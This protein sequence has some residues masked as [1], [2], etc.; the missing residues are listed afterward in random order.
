MAELEEVTTRGR[1]WRRKR[2]LLPTGFLLLVLLLLAIV[3]TQRVRI[4]T[5]YI[6]RELERRDVRASYT[7]TRIGFRTQRLEDVVIGDPARPDLTADRVE[8][9]IAWGLPGPTVSFIKARGVRLFGRI[10]DRKVS[11]GEVDKLL[12]EPTGKPFEFPD[13]NVDLADTA[14]VLDTQAGRLVGAI[15][16][17]GNLADGF[18]GEMTVLSSELLLG[19]CAFEEPRAYVDVAI[20]ERRPNIDGPISAERMLCPGADVDLANPVLNV[21][22]NVSETL[23]SWRGS[24]RLSV[25]RAQLGTNSAAGVTGRITFDGRKRL[26]RGRMDLTAV[27]AQIGDFSAARTTMQGRYAISLGTG[28]L[29][30]IADAAARGMRAQGP[31]VDSI[32]TALDGLGGTPVGPLGDAL[33]AAVRRAANG[34]D[35]VA[36]LRLVN[37]KGYGGVRFD[38]LSVSSRS[39]AVFGLNGGQ[40]LTYYWP[41]G[42]ARIDGEFGLT[43]GGFPATR[44]SLSQPRAGA[45]M[46]GEARVAPFAAGNARIALAPI[47]FRAE[48]DGTTRIETGMVLSGPFNDGYVRDLAL[49][50]VGRV[51]NGGFTLG[52]ECTPASFRSL[53][54]AELVLG[55]T[56]LALCPTG[57]ALVW[58]QGDGPLRGGAR[59]ERPLLVGRLGRNPIRISADSLRFDIDDPGFASSGVKVR[60]GAGEGAHWL[61]IGAISG[62]FDA[63]GVG[64]TFANASGKLSAVPILLSDAEG[65]WRVVDG[66]LTIEGATTVSDAQDPPRFWPLR[67]DDFRLTLVD[68]RID[69][70]A[71]LLDPETGT[72]VTDVTIEHSLETGIGNAVLDVPGIT[73]EVGGY[74]PDELTR[75]TTGVVALVDGTLTGKGRINWSPEGTTSTGTFSTADMDL[76]APFGPVEGL[77]TTV[78]FTD[79]LALESAPGQVAEVDLIQTG[80]DVVD[81]TIRYQL[82]RDLKVRVESGHW[83]FA[84]GD[85]FLEE[86][87]L[88][89]SKPTTKILTFRVVGLDAAT[90]VEQ[91]DFTVIEATGTFDG[92]IPMEFDQS[93]GRIIGGRL[94]AR[95]PGGTISYVGP[96]SDQALGT[97]GKAAFDALKSLRYDKFIINLNGSLQGEFLAGIELDGV[98]RNTQVGGI[99]GFVLN[100]LSDLRLE[101][102]I[103]IK[104]PIRALIATARSFE[105]PSSVIQPVLPPELQG[106]PI[107]VIA[108]DKDETETVQPQES[109]TMP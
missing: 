17:R 29:T 65:Q 86:T 100:Q 92:V 36:S 18:R 15:E 91:M 75:L 13:I 41:S 39:G 24:A 94:E 72:R 68:N 28:N 63:P 5:G 64:G 51:G 20:I 107:E 73:F 102:N 1:R 71:W 40:G 12:P 44:V 104:G 19:K 76:A 9:R 2:V 108:Q 10:I 53:Q 48:P 14:I 3:W 56:N 52:E 80:I 67:S 78:N 90:F 34:F 49:R 109:E 23:N 70:T 69:A 62:D 35:A 79:L 96:V 32:A 42:N 11:F 27:Q 95:P 106:L 57:R 46:R 26:T 55:R 88:D 25:Q 81:G 97:I 50:I 87:V 101:F 33:A 61:D 37:G 84:G 66:D 103:S 45:P 82:L 47:R 4:A 85:L 89:F 8:V 16:G 99:A 38:K 59:V 74:Q 7:V 60:L 83:P 58:K 21:D 31:T 77:T 105:D 30:V 6:E 43:G 54:A 98:A 93:G 22:A